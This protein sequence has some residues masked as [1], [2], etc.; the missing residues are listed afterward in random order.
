MNRKLRLNSPLYKKKSEK[1]HTKKTIALV[2]FCLL[3]V[4]SSFFSPLHQIVGGS[5]FKL[6]ENWKGVP[7][8]NTYKKID[9]NNLLPSNYLPKNLLSTSSNPL[10]D[11]LIDGR[12][13]IG[14]GD[15]SILFG[16]PYSFSTS[17]FVL[18]SSGKYASNNPELSQTKA[19]KGVLISEIEENSDIIFTSKVIYTY[20]NLLITQTLEPVG[21]DLED[22]ENTSKGNYYKIEYEIEN[23]SDAS[24]EV[25]FTL[26]L[27]PMINADDICKLSA[28]GSHIG[29]NRKFETNKIPLHFAF[30]NGDLQAHLI[31]KHKNTI[32]PDMAYI[33]QWAYLTNV[34]YLE[35]QKVGNYTDDS[36]IILRWNTETLQKGEVRTFR[37]FYGVPKGK[38]GINLQHHQPEK[39]SQIT[40]YFDA[41]QSQ[42]SSEEETRL[43]EFIGARR[44]KAALVEGYT[45]AKGS[46]HVNLELS[47]DRINQVSYA[48]Q[49]FGVKYEKILHKSHG[50]FFARNDDVTRGSGEQKDRK[51]VVT[52][53]R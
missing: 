45:D 5:F 41:N 35:Q 13:T 9:N 24:R 22:L 18:Q 11:Q 1:K 46:Q 42:L 32:S 4:F 14:Y 17:H 3:F 27:D 43:R 30:Y 15:K 52:V 44:W 6:Y 49:M 29:M 48:L 31:T 25:E 12:F 16:Y 10:D 2:C 53:W 51:V 34:L 21:A 38:E 7:Y 40:L 33:G 8:T 47:K 50:E 23:Q 39:K 20:D 28:D 19:L 36:A 26:L 37:V